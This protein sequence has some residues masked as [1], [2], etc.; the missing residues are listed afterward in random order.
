MLPV[1]TICLGLFLVAARWLFR[2]DLEVDPRLRAAVLELDERKMITHPELL[3]KSLVV[4]GLTLLGFL[5]H[6]PLHLERAL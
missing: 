2:N 1:S 3:R 6:G 4:L 5:F